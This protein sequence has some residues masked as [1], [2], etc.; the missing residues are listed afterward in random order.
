MNDKSVH[1][2]DRALNEHIDYKLENNRRLWILIQEELQSDISALNSNLEYAMDRLV[3]L[4]EG[5]AKLADLLDKLH[6]RVVELEKWRAIN[7]PLYS[8]D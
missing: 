6:D 5:N 1:D 4:S 2:P 7:E 8:N 3:K